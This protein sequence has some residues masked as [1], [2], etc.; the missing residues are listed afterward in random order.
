M[1]LA[2]EAQEWN[3]ETKVYRWTGDYSS[4]RAGEGITEVPHDIPAEAEEVNLRYNQIVVIRENAFS[5]LNVCEKLYLSRNKI[6]AIEVGAWNGLISLKTLTLFNNEIEVLKKDSFSHLSACEEL[7]LGYNNIHSIEVRALDGLISLKMLS[8]Q[9]NELS[10]LP[11][12]IFGK[13]HPAQLTLRLYNNPVECN[14][15]MCWIQQGQ[16]KGWLTL[17]NYDW[18]PSVCSF[19]TLTC[20]QLG[21]Y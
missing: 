21:R 11:W 9:Y 4:W 2:V 14:S 3:S 8:L 15:S 16:Q 1:V 6:H 19:H 17:I 5:H 10:T 12:T 18:K 7:D 20:Q 13:E